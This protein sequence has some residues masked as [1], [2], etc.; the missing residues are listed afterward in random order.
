MGFHQRKKWITEG[1]WVCAIV[2]IGL[3]WFASRNTAAVRERPGSATQASGV[4][5]TWAGRSL[6]VGDHPA[7]KNED[8]V[9]RFIPVEGH[10]GAFTSLADKIIEGKRVPMGSLQFEYNAADGTLTSEFERGQM[11]GVW[12]FTLN[13]DAMTGTL[14][15]LPNKDLARKVS[16]RRVND[17]DLPPAPA[18]DEYK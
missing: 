5:G 4:L 11:H 15:V 8:V 14:E 16:V 2:A 3:T 13:G 17:D 12:T 1:L 7:C 10:P 18:I 9:Y 6:C